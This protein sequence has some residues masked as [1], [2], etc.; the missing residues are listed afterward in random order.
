MNFCLKTGPDACKGLP[1]F[2]PD[3]DSGVQDRCAALRAG[4]PPPLHADRICHANRNHKAGNGAG[5]TEK[6]NDN[7]TEEEN[8][9]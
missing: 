7:V 1:V 6:E 3:E 2:P 8:G 9:N 5:L 4:D